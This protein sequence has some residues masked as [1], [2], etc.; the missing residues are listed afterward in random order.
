MTAWWC[1]EWP[2]SGE[3]EHRGH[4]APA[5]GVSGGSGQ[6]CPAQA[7]KA[8]AWHGPPTEA[9]SSVPQQLSLSDGDTWLSSGLRQPLFWGHHA[10]GTDATRTKATPQHPVVI[11]PAP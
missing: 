11:A 6:S 2:G 9:H 10:A 3:H 7:F 1:A 8:R 5:R 4:Q